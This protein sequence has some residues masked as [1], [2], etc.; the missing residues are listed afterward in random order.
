MLSIIFGDVTL[1]SW[2]I[3]GFK[4]LI[5]TEQL[6]Y[7]LH[8]KCLVKWKCLELFLESNLYNNKKVLCKRGALTMSQL[9]TPFP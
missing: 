2:K 4:I 3:I 8:G 5:F 6:W 9:N 7:N 1:I